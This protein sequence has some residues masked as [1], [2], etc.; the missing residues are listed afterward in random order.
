MSN[1]VPKAMMGIE[2]FNSLEQLKG[3]KG[4]TAEAEKA[5]LKKATK[6]FEAFFTHHMLKT[7]RKT[8]PESSTGSE[9]GFGV[10]AGKDMFTDLFDM[11]L[12]R[13]MSGGNENSISDILYRS[14][15]PLLMAQFGEYGEDIE[16]KPLHTPQ[17]PMNLDNSTPVKLQRNREMMPFPDMSASGQSHKM[18][19]ATGSLSNVLSLYSDHIHAAARET[20]LDPALIASVIK[21]E[22]NGDPRAV[23]KAGAKGL[24]QLV[25]ST[26]KDMGVKQVFD[27][28]QNIRAG[29]RFLKK[30]VDR[31]DDTKL[32][33]AAY[34]AGPAKVDR[35]GGV[36]PYRETE[37]YIEKVMTAFQSM[38]GES[39]PAKAKVR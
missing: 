38:R 6:E 15:E 21:A 8:I 1:P 11:E 27:P 7:M 16:M 5:R 13:K 30:M 25:D 19:Q 3:T 2:S 36:P 12:A 17:S 33:L 18:K 20:G 26:A 35:Y 23:S 37:Q 29:S 28:G 24:M 10:G 32:A 9:G 14:M 4:A 22:S 34:N 39:A 31:F